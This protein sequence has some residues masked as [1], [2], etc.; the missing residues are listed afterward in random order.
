MISLVENALAA[1]STSLGMV[2]A[3]TTL[4]G[5]AAAMHQIGFAAISEVVP[6]KRRRLAQG[7]FQS[8][9]AIGSATGPIIGRLKGLASLDFHS[10]PI[11]IYSRI[12]SN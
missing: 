1:K 7:L 3:G 10:R 4:I 8:S 12:C 6:R 2:I 9:L 5:S 11:L